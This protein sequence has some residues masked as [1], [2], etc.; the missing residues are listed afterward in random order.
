MGKNEIINTLY[1]T[2]I[3]VME[4]GNGNVSVT[5]QVDRR[6][7]KNLNHD[8]MTTKECNNNVEDELWKKRIV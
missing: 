3:V 8:R 2:I 6:G 1:N 5:G 4:R 7:D